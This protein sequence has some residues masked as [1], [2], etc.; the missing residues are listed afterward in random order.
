[1][2]AC[3]GASLKFHLLTCRQIISICS[4]IYT[5]VIIV[6][7]LYS[8]QSDYDNCNNC[9]VETE[10]FNEECSLV[11]FRFSKME[12]VDGLPSRQSSDAREETMVCS[13]FYIVRYSVVK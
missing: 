2:P 5:S 13:T 9:V 6:P 1:M 11:G 12:D 7:L 3:G 8:L 4:I 10:Y